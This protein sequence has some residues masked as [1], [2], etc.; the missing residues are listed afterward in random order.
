M[1]GLLGVV[2]VICLASF[3]WQ[4]VWDIKY[5]RE[6]E[7]CKECGQAKPEKFED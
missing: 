7:F 1:C 6:V 5:P 3:V 2:F 4:I